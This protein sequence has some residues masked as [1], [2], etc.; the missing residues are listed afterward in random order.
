MLSQVKM[1]D[2]QCDNIFYTRCTINNKI[3]GIM[4]D[5]RSCTNVASTI[6]VDKLDLAAIKHPHPY[7]LQWLNDNGHVRVTK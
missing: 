3:C 6:L 1:N 5:G 4:I 2:E 7:R